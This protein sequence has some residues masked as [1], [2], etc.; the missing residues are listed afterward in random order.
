MKKDLKKVPD[1]YLEGETGEM[2]KKSLFPLPPPQ[3]PPSR[4]AFLKIYSLVSVITHRRVDNQAIKSVF[5][6]IY[7]N[8]YLKLAHYE[9]EQEMN[10]GENKFLNTFCCQTGNQ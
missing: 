5:L 4:G 6:L 9:Q 7:Y 2:K 1:T 8:R 3:P 10:E